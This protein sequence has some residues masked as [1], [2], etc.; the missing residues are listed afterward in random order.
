MI[1]GHGQS[2]GDIVPKKSPNNSQEAEGMEGR[3]PVKGNVQ[4]HHLTGHRPGLK[5]CRLA[6][7]R[8]RIG[9]AVFA[10]PIRHY[11]RQEPDAVKPLVRIR[12]GAARKGCP[13]PD[14]GQVRY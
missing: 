13:Y 12:G 14:N 9:N 1:D 8:I 5:R 7:E 2:H 10:I 6:L 4:E 3:S 11:P